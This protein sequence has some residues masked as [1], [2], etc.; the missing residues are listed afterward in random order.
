MTDLEMFKKVL[1]I[2]RCELEEG[3]F[4]ISLLE[5]ILAIEQS[6]QYLPCT[7][8]YNLPLYSIL[9]PIVNCLNLLLV[10]LLIIIF[11][12]GLYTTSKVDLY[13]DKNLKITTDKT[14]TDKK[15]MI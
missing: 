2:I 4:K 15:N 7:T 1:K 3:Y 6:L 8:S 11:I 13:L 9:V 5:Q 12:I 14:K 10:M